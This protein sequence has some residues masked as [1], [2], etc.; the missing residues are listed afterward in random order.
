MT[1]ATFFE[2]ND[3]NRDSAAR[4]DQARGRGEVAPRARILLVDDDD[5]TRD[6]LETMLRAEGFVTST[7]PDGE[8]ALTE[9]ERALPDVVLTDLQMPRMDGVELCRRLHEIDRDLPVIVMTGHSDMQAVMKSLRAGAEDYLIK[10]LQYDAVVWCVERTITRRAEKRDHEELYRA[11]IERLVFS[12]IR[13]QEHADA[14]AEQR[15][16]LSALLQNLQE[17]VAIGDKNGGLLMLNDAARAIFGFGG[18]DAPIV[19][20]E[21]PEAFD[22]D[23]RPV[24]REQHP[25]LRA[26]RGEQFTDYE[27]FYARSSGDW[28]RVVATGTS[29]KDEHGDI[30]L[31]IVVFHDVTDVRRLERQREE[32]VAL[33]SHDLCSPLN[34][35]LFSVS[36]L[37]RS[38]AQNGTTRT[39]GLAER[40]EENVRRMTAMLGELNEATSLE[41][42]GV[43]MQVAM[44]D[45]GT[46]VGRV[47]GCMDEAR[48]VRITIETEDRSPF[49]VR[50]DASRLERVVSNLLT[51]ALKYSAEDAPVNVRLA[52]KGSDVELEVVD[53]GIGIAPEN[54][55][56]L[57]DRYFR[58]TTG[59]ARASGLGLGL[60]IARLVVDAHGG[61]IEVSSE[62]GTGST[63]RVILPS[64][65]VAV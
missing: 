32:Y 43:T 39:T 9:V 27:L 46:L 2:E 64:Y 33:I 12:I 47:V 11:L 48:A 62:V 17:G 6:A 23:G 4:T 31:T 45:L 25:F 44:C 30:A 34:S 40:I 16:E 54:V 56:M 26:A 60:Y 59:Q 63:F 21:L 58:T 61:R 57:F 5:G 55:K 50:A 28:R 37:K 29:V 65:A 13:E 15:A 22:L 35:V 7:A 10:P 42:H 41:A 8:A 1:A 52:R 19:Q 51:N 18:G 49:V 38:I 20:M 53:R 36:M 3:G 14:E 24:E